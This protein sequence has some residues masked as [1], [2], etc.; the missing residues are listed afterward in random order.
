MK[1]KNKNKNNCGDI[2][3]NLKVQKFQNNVVHR[4]ISY[5][6]CDIRFKFLIIK[7][8]IIDLTRFYRRLFVCEFRVIKN[9]IANEFICEM[10]DKIQNN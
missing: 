7:I 2:H 9:N 6:R 10:F 5:N 8:L 4:T 1:F 3:Y